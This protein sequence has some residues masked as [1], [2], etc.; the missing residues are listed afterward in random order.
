[1]LPAPAITPVLVGL[2]FVLAQLCLAFQ[3]GDMQDQP[4]DPFKLCG[5]IILRRVITAQGLARGRPRRV[6]SGR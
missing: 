6:R 4:D 2:G 3:R 1:M 5:D